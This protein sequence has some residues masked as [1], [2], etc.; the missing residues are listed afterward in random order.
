MVELFTYD[1]F[2]KRERDKAAKEEKKVA[3]ATCDNCFGRGTLLFTSPFGGNYE[4][5]C[6]C[7]YGVGWI[8][9]NWE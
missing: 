8:A 6:P 3:E 9:K 7:C 2:A 5:E 4:G 1:P